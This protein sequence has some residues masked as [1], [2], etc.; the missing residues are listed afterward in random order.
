MFTTHYPFHLSEPVYAT[1][2]CFTASVEVQKVRE[3]LPY[4]DRLPDDLQ[5]ETVKNLDV[6]V[7]YGGQTLYPKLTLEWFLGAGVRFRN[8][9]R[10]DVGFNALQLSGNGERSFQDKKFRLEAGIRV[11]FQL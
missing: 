9:L 6:L 10:Q 2:N 5:K 4:I 1:T 7:H 11:G 8:N 3:G